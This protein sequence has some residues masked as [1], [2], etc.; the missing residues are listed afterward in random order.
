MQAPFR[1]WSVLGRWPT[2]FSF[3]KAHV[4]DVFH[5][6]L[7]GTLWWPRHKGHYL[8]WS[9][10]AYSRECATRPFTSWRLACAGTVAGYDHRWR[11]LGATAQL[12]R[13]LPEHSSNCL[14]RRGEMLWPISPMCN[15][16]RATR[17][18]GQITSGVNNTH[19]GNRISLLGIP[20]LVCFWTKSSRNYKYRGDVTRRR[21]QDKHLSRPQGLVLRVV[22]PS[23][24]IT[25]LLYTHAIT[26]PYQSKKIQHWTPISHSHA[27]RNC[28]R[29]KDLIIYGQVSSIYAVHQTK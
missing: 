22:S 26:S 23:L 27:L 16:K 20:P 28:D 4:N 21:K 7:R 13:P 11:Y 29:I 17:V 2:A 25:P 10:V 3:Q 15:G 8:G 5:V 18:L 1:S 6:E 14:K 19:L 12:Q 24:V 9:V